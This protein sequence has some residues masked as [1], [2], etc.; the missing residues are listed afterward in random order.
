MKISIVI[1]IYCVSE[2]IESCLESVFKQT[3]ENIECIL[4]DDASP[5]N[6]MDIAMEVIK[7][8]RKESDVII[9]THPKNR[10]LSAARN[11]GI[12]NASGDYLYF[13]DSDDL[14]PHNSIECLCKHLEAEPDMV[15]GNYDYIDKNIVSVN[16]KKL[17]NYCIYQDEDIL[18]SFLEHRWPEM[19]WNKLVKRDFCVDNKLYFQEGLIHEDNLWSFEVAVI[20]KR[21]IVCNEK[22]YL[23]R[24]REFSITQE[25]SKKNFQSTIDI[26]EQ[27]IQC[28]KDKNLY[29]NH[30]SLM[31]Y[32]SNIT[33]FLYKELVKSGM[34]KDYVHFVRSEIKRLMN[35]VPVEERK[36]LS[37]S[38]RSKYLFFV[39]PHI[40][41]S[42]IIRS[43][44]FFQQVK[45]KQ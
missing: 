3:Y 20:A 30:S 19:A 12:L 15:V 10:G 29:K 24:I 17:I 26:V 41:S 28:S 31:D 22:T 33:Y 27:M 1:P 44:L 11:T 25:K 7:K 34:N 16:E 13:L 4:V 6:S 45:C 35:I 32:W 37:L 43:I 40:I 36:T 42:M 23:Y 18:N 9:I 14:L 8:N 2:Y 39:F 21:I 5:D 38:G